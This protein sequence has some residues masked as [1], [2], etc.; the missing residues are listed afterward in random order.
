MG[1]SAAEPPAASRSVLCS[2]QRMRCQPK[3]PCKLFTVH[4]RPSTQLEEVTASPLCQCSK[5]H[6]CPRRHTDPGSLP[7]S[8]YGDSLGVKVYSGHC[9]PV[10]HSSE[11]VYTLVK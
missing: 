8:Y 7:S 5:G 11:P 10:R 2:L 3:E 1:R 6:R 4:K 9:V